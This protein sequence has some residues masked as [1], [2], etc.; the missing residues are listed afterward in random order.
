MNSITNLLKAYSNNQKAQDAIRL[1]EHTSSS[2]FLTGKAGTG[3]S[4]LLTYLTKSLSKKHIILAPTELAALQVGGENIHSFFGFEWRAYLPNDKGIPPLPP[5]TIQLLEEI[6]LIIID[7]ISMVRCD[8]MNAIDLSLRANL[9]SNLPFGGK[10]LLMIGDLYQL[11]PIIDE[12]DKETVNLL[13]TH[14]TSRY[15]FSAKAFEGDYQYQI[16]ELSKVYRQRD[17]KFISL[18]NAIRVNQLDQQH[19]NLLNERYDVKGGLSSN[20]KITLASTNAVIKQLNEENLAAIEAPL[21][22]FHAEELGNFANVGSAYPTD[23][24][25]RIKVGAQIMFVKDDENEQWVNGTIGRITEIFE[26]KLLVEI[27]AG[28]AT[29][30]VSVS[31][32]TWHKYVY[33]WNHETETVERKPIGSFTQLPVKLAWGIT[34]HKSQGQTFDHVIINLGRKAFATGQT[35]VALSRCTSFKGITLKRPVSPE[36][37]FVDKRITRFLEAQKQYR[38]D[39][40]SYMTM[41]EHTERSIQQQHLIIS[42]LEEKSIQARQ[43]MQQLIHNL[44]EQSKRVDWLTTDL[45]AAKNNLKENESKLGQ[46]LSDLAEKEAEVTNLSGS[47]GIYQIVIVVLAIACL[48]LLFS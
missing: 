18:L 6:E 17:K 36:D 30:I 37:I 9:R 48:W 45:E 19:L 15:F 14:Y 38:A 29:E 8:L 24:E 35:Y 21:V 23:K 1:I 2:V 33:Q 5:T 46:A 43:E 11:P 7:E 42:S 22:T 27:K 39:K 3:K 31:H 40:N 34:I 25:L 26:D 41:L 13:R 28:K 10:Q 47:K 16:V 20:F 32:H 4:T 12:R 44:V